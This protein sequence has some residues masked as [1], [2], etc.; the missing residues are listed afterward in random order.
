MGC[1]TLINEE[2][3]HLIGK[4]KVSRLNGWA[5]FFINGKS[6]YIHQLIM[7]PLAGMYVVHINGNRLDN[8]RS[9]LQMQCY[10]Y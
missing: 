3:F 5:R 9:N 4:K 2:D 1:Q 8:R 10:N 7:N 6:V